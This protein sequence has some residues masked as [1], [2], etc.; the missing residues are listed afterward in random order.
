MRGLDSAAQTATQKVNKEGTNARHQLDEATV[1]LAA[2]LNGMNRRDAQRALGRAE[3]DL[4]AAV[5]KLDADMG[6]FAVDT[7]TSSRRAPLEKALIEAADA[8]TA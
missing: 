7:K 4:T 3:G 2:R 5:N 1:Q 6:K 8:L